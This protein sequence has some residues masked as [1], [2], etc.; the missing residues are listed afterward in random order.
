M[1][2]IYLLFV[3]LVLFA[4]VS[5]IQITPQYPTNIIVRGFN[6]V[7]PLTLKITDAVP[8]N[9][10]LYTLS[11]MSIQPSSTFRIDS[12]SFNKTFIIKP[13]ENLN[14]NGNYAFAYTLN[15][16]GVKKYKQEILLKLLKLKDVIKISSASISPASNH[17]SFYVQNKEAV[18]LK[19]LT[20][21]FS[22]VLFNVTTT[23]DLKPNERF[24]IPVNVKP[25]LMSKTSAGVYVV[26]GRFKAGKGD[27]S[28]EGNLYIGEKKNITTLDDKSGLLIRTETISKVNA[29][30]VAEPIKI[31]MERNIFSRLFTT[32][33][34]APNSIQRDGM[35]IHYSWMKGNLMPS[36]SYTVRAETNYIFPF[37]ILLF[38]SLAIA[39]Y[40]RFAETKLEVRKSVAPMKTKGGEFA[41]RVT[42]SLKAR[43]DVE[44]VTLSD[45]IPVMVKIYKKFSTV[46]PDKIDSERRK[47]HWTV[48]N[49]EAGEERSF[50]YIVYSK[51]GIVGKF[52][53]PRAV[54][55]FEQN[56][57][58]QK[59]DSNN[60]FFMN[61]Q[62]D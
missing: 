45:K 42:L 57:E 36:E 26:N 49:L 28:I 52:S 46:K 25:S 19:N 21:T 38:L 12:P 15:H 50:S 8:G 37:L 18:Y 34:V 43:Q 13:N 53:L 54:S 41:L 29:G 56:G 9:Y 10:N 55:V 16:R 20:A 51:V 44:K 59:I 4:Q 35:T 47:I 40:L 33:S 6:N 22:S 48:G 58:V 3:A 62:V 27:V 17:I 24:V 60:V 2:N 39:G 32:F 31:Q 23:F 14:I 61:E 5:A 30:N 7:I 11:D 1:K